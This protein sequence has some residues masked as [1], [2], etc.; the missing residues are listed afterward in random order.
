MLRRK[1]E[2]RE[3][4]EEEE[5]TQLHEHSVQHL[6]DRRLGGGRVYSLDFLE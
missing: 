5:E 4:E 3:T 6:I 2:G 1:E